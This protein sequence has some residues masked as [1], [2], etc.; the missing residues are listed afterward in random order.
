[1]YKYGG[2]VLLICESGVLP[3][4]KSL[5]VA[6]VDK[7]LNL[8]GHVGPLL[9]SYASNYGSNQGWQAVNLPD[10]PMLLINVPGTSVGTMFA[11][12]ST[13]GAWSIFTGWS[14][15]C[16]ARKGSELYYGTTNKVVRAWTGASDFGANITATMLTAYTPV[17][18]PRNKAIRAMRPTFTSTGPFSYTLGLSND[19]A[20]DTYTANQIN[21]GNISAALWGSAVWGTSL[22]SGSNLLTR[23]WR[24][25]PD[26]DG[27]YK[28]IYLQ[29]ASKSAQV[30]LQSIDALIVD[31]GSF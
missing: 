23:D 28:A 10:I 6:S 18:G 19:F 21:L 16:I 1:L 30:S 29:V 12:H 9:A 25:I 3:V 13:S 2:E 5:Q 26:R 27:V 31:H 7:T 20:V 22:W 8:T 17:K 24:T 14:A 15:N 4:S 11:M